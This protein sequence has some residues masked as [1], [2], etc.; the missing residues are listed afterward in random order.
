MHGK[1][2]PYERSA[3]THDSVTLMMTEGGASGAGGE[4]KMDCFYFASKPPKAVLYGGSGSLTDDHSKSLARQALFLD[5]PLC[6]G[7]TVLPSSHTFTLLDQAGTY[8]EVVSLRFGN[9]IFM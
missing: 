5:L 3:C 6:H 1:E 9:S 4:F 7:S 8:F 2:G